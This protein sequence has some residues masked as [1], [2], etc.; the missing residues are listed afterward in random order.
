MSALSNILNN[1]ITGA[2]INA[3]NVIRNILC[4]KEKFEVTSKIIITIIITILTIAF[5]NKAIVGL[6]PLI[7]SVAYIWL[8]TVK[9]VTKFKMLSMFSNLMWLIYEIYINL[10]AAAVFDVLSII[11][12]F[13]AIVQIYIE[14]K[15]QKRLL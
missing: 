4:Y 5:N 11:I 9:D 10:Y 2:I 1:G 14:R 15:K 13:I 8:M 12:N 6:L 3:V 7:A